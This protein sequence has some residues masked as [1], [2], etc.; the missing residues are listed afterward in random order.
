VVPFGKNNI[1]KSNVLF[2]VDSFFCVRPLLFGRLI[3]FRLAASSYHF[4]L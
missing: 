1:N 3:S 4:K 2:Y